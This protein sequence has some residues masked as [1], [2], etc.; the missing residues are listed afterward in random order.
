MEGSP[1]I[2]A[3][4]SATIPVNGSISIS[5]VIQNKELFDAHAEEVVNDFKEF[6]AY[7]YAQ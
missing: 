7:A 5:H 4:M 1:V 6:D 2:V 3:F